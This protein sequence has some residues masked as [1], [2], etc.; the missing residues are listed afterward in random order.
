M[1]FDLTESLIDSILDAMDNQTSVLVLD[2]KNGVIVESSQSTSNK[3]QFIGLPQWTSAD[4]FKIRQQFVSDLHS[5]L[6]RDELQQILHSGRGVFRNFKNC[7]K[8]YP[9]IEKRWHLFKRNK[10]LGKINEWYNALREIWGL[11]ALPEEPEDFENLVQNDFVFR[12]YNSALDKE[13]ILQ[14]AG[15]ETGAFGDLLENEVA[16]ALAFL[17]KC[18][19]QTQTEDLGFVC[20]TLSN[21]FAGC[22]T[23]QPCPSNSAKTV[24]LTAF[25]VLQN[26]RGL[27]IGKELLSRSLEELSK[28]KIQWVIIANVIIPDQMIPLLDRSGFKKFGSGYIAKL[29]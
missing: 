21:E 12:E 28:R 14:Y 26:F 13:L 3:E 5:P 18:R 27:G 20:R 15:A 24:V 6:A 22:I 25:F 29:F 19:F 10:M 23:F 7:L 2:T 4:G 9:E 1:Y 11:E 16:G 17:W 8:Q